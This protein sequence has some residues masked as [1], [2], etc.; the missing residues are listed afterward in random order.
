MDAPRTK[1]VLEMLSNFKAVAP[2]AK[3]LHLSANFEPTIFK[4]TG[5]VPRITSKTVQAMNIEDVL[6]NDVLLLTKAD[7]AALEQHFTT[8]PTE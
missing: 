2:A 3:V 8:N 1:A 5:N 6:G 7:L 4:S